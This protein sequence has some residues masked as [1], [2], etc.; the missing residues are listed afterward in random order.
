M[1]IIGYP[2]EQVKFAI[3][4]K[5][6]V[7]RALHCILGSLFLAL[8]A[9]ITLYL[10]YSPVP[11]SMQTFALFLLILVQGKNKATASVTLYLVQAALGMPVLATGVNPLWMVGPTAGYLIGFLGCSLVAGFLLEKQA[12]HGFFRTFLCFVAGLA[13]IY[14]AG[15][16]FLYAFIAGNQAFAIG[17]LP[18]L[19]VDLLKAAAVASLSVPINAIRKRH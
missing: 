19:G 5:T 4:K 17:V 8:M 16:L 11:I 6:K 3:S 15:T 12:N 7:V 9:Q 10:P 13:V 18:F 2:Q 1:S 14:A